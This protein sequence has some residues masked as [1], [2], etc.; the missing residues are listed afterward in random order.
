MTNKSRKS[1]AKFIVFVFALDKLI[2]VLDYIYNRLNIEIGISD[3]II[4]SIII[5]VAIPLSIGIMEYLFKE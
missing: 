4:L 5:I 3:V 2:N 1:I